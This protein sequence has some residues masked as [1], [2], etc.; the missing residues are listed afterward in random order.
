[1]IFFPLEKVQNGKRLLGIGNRHE[2]SLQFVV[3][4]EIIRALWFISFGW[5]RTSSTQLTSTAA[6]GTIWLIA[7][8]EYQADAARSGA[9]RLVETRGQAGAVACTWTAVARWARYSY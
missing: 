1:M 6:A 5:V 9:G 3:V 7:L 2:N 8:V 4:V